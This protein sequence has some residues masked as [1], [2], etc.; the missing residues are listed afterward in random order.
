AIEWG[1][2]HR[3]EDLVRIT[4]RV[5]PDRVEFIVRDEGAGFDRANLP[6]AAVPDDPMAHMDVREKLGI[7][8]GGFGLLISK[9]MVDALR[10]NDRGN[11]VPFIKRSP[12]GPA[13]PKGPA[14]ATRSATP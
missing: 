4:Y 3:I 11:E 5:H 13:P 9:G 14:Q 1:N 2:K 6:H 12:P 10:Y 7:R 8:E